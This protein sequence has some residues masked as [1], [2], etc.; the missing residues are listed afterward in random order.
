MS[1]FENNILTVEDGEKI[2][3]GEFSHKKDIHQVLFKGKVEIGDSAF[4]GCTGITKLTSPE[5]TDIG[6]GV[7][8]GCTSLTEVVI[9]KGAKSIGKAAFIYCEGI[10]TLVISYGVQ[11]VNKM[12]FNL[13]SSL[14]SV[15]IPD[16]V[17]VLG[18]RHLG[19]VQV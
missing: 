9:S 18:M 10:K 17:R 4:E 2:E 15:V 7:F 8:R 3:A 13:C 16:S 12:A 1:K 11:S 5:G 14:T 19:T 6:Y